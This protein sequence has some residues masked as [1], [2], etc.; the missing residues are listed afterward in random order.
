MCCSRGGPCAAAI[1][2]A[3]P[4]TTTLSFASRPPE[5]V[6]PM[7]PVGPP[8]SSGNCSTSSE[9]DT[10]S[11]S[12]SESSSEESGDEVSHELVDSTGGNIVQQTNLP[13]QTV[14]PMEEAKPQNRWNLK[15]F[16]KRDSPSLGGEQPAE[17][18]HPTPCKV[19]APP[20]AA[21]VTSNDKMR[22]SKSFTAHH[23]PVTLSF[24]S[25]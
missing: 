23:A 14:E 10:D 19:S 9:E 25:L 2:T 24:T 6:A 7:S 4:P 16:L 20:T 21:A 17:S 13:S 15:S 3:S 5:P 8:Q 22:N 18:K 1:L 11:E 12:E